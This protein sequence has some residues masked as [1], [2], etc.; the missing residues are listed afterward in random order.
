MRISIPI[1]ITRRTCMMMTWTIFVSGTQSLTCRY[2][3]S[4]SRPTQP[5]RDAKLDAIY[6]LW[7]ENVLIDFIY[8]WTKRTGERT[9]KRIKSKLVSDIPRDMRWKRV[10]MHRTGTCGRRICYCRRQ[11]LFWKKDTSAATETNEPTVVHPSWH[12]GDTFIRAILAS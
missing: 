9:M 10:D 3:R 7:Q 1:L 4:L 5:N 2:L 8:P 11:F 6:Q 12:Y